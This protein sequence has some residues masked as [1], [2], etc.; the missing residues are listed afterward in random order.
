M[1]TN[2]NKLDFL[3]VVTSVISAVS[4][5]SNLSALRTL[6]ILRPLRTISRVPSLKKMLGTIFASFATL[7]D[8]IVIMF[9]YYTLFASAG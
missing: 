3:I 9:F 5:S 6:R 4:S 7:K 2:W 1:S 8:V